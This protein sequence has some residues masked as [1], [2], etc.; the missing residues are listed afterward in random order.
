[1][2]RFTQSGQANTYAGLVGESFGTFGSIGVQIC[3]IITNLG[4][5]IIYLIIIGKFPCLWFYNFLFCR[6]NLQVPQISTNTHFSIMESQFQIFASSGVLGLS[7]ILF[8]GCQILCWLWILWLWTV[9]FCRIFFFFRSPQLQISCL[10][11]CFCIS[12]SKCLSSS[13]F[14]APQPL[15]IEQ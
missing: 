5:L 8:K 12:G 9:P 11:I 15:L 10:I 1:M 3:V 6:L 14:L 2:L 13:P 4:C 7:M